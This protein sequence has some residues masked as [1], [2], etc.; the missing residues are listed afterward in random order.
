M[1]CELDEAIHLIDDATN[2]TLP[3]TYQIVQQV[4]DACI[5][6]KVSPENLSVDATGAGAPFCDVL[7]GEWSDQ[8]LR[9][10]FGGRASDKKVSVNSRQTGTESYMNRVSELWWVGKELIRTKQ[11][12]GISNDLAKEMTARKYDMVKKRVRCV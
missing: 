11:L 10:S 1:F 2:K 3:R 9:V 5:K 12:F 8:F 4:K 6:K 7:A